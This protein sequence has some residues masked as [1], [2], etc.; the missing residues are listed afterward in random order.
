MA[1]AF[2]MP[3]YDTAFSLAPA[4]GKK[5]PRIENGKHLAW[6]R[7]LPCII[8]GQYGVEAAHIR[9]A[10]PHLGKR[11]TGKAEKPDDRWTVPLSP[12]MHREQHS[13][14]EQDFWQR[15][16]IDPC[17]VAMALHGVSG[18]DEAALVIIRNARMRR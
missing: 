8:T 9:Y 3:R 5:R 18:D 1:A 17:Q 4:K 2:R 11:D 12:E 13:M 14:N 15:H 10:A 7:T 16:K 6:I